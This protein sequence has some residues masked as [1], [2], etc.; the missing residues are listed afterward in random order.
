MAERCKEDSLVVTWLPDGILFEMSKHKVSNWEEEDS[1]VKVP[2]YLLRRS[3]GICQLNAILLAKCNSLTIL[4]LLI[5]GICG[6][7]H[8]RTKGIT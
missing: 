1:T 7:T 4:Y 8:R 5:N 2:C 6:Q 3:N